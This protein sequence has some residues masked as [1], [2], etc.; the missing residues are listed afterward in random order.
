MDTLPGVSADQIAKVAGVLNDGKRPL[1]ERFRALFTLRNLGGDAAVEGIA[2][3]FNDPSALLKHELA[4]CLGQMRNQAAIP[5]LTAVLRD[6]LQEPMVRHEAGEAL[7]AVGA[8]ESLAV[9]EEFENDPR[10]EVSET[11]RLA[12]QRI[13]WLHDDGR[14]KEMDEAQSRNPY[15]SVDP[16][17]P[18]EETNVEKLTTVLLDEDLPLFERYRAMF[19]LRNRGDDASVAAL[20]RGLSAGSALFR[21]EIAYVLGQIQSA[22]AVPQLVERLQLADENE[23]VRH[24]CAEALG[25]IAHD[26]CKEVLERYLNDEAPT[27][28]KES[29]IVALDM[30][31][32]ENSPEFQYA[33][34]LVRVA[35]S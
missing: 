17:P 4:Y 16:A 8:A 21:H 10:P 14:R 27:V 28:V 11:C 6:T 29:C 30:C 33:D 20:A 31:E 23:M 32:Y 5:F 3:A 19:A 35:E 22:V 26:E 34:G 24:E 13:R 2:R 12:A 15:C 7:G 18:M 1:K 9:L 25:S